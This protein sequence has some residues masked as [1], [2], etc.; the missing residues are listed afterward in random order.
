MPCFVHYFR[1]QQYKTYCNRLRSDRLAATCTLLRFRNQG[2]NLGFD[3]FR[4]R[5][6]HKSGDVINFII[7]ACR[8]SSRLKSYKNCK[9]NRS[10]LAKGIV[11]NKMSCF[12]GSLCS[13]WRGKVYP[14]IRKESTTSRA[15]KW[16]TLLSLAKI[17][18][19][20]NFENRLIFDEVKAY[21]KTVPFLAT[22]Y[23]TFY[24]TCKRTKFQEFRQWRH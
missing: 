15:L 7:V 4:V 22:L 10:R 14:D 5:C 16:G 23:I 1:F 21:Q 13:F 19:W 24:I 3:F 9:K 12:Y 2:K 17:W 8:I 11:K 20:N 18:Q 6:A